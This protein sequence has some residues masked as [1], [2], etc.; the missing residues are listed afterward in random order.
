MQ[1]ETET[2][3]NETAGVDSA[4]AEVDLTASA[5]ASAAAGAAIMA[6]IAASGSPAPAEL[7]RVDAVKAA[8]TKALKADWALRQ[9]LARAEKSLRDTR[10]ML[11]GKAA[12]AAAAWRELA[13]AS[14][15]AASF[16]VD[17]QKEI[18]EKLQKDIA[19]K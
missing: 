5:E 3:Q 8:M 15:S 6:V 18:V 13:E 19:L 14:G 10:A 7:D 16:C 9:S 11:L 2:I 4:I 1:N 17:L 12:L